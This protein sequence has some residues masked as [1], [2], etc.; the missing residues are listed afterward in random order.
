MP[1]NEGGRHLVESERVVKL[2]VRVRFVFC[3]LGFSFTEYIY[4]ASFSMW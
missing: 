1:F 3:I 2:R 4:A